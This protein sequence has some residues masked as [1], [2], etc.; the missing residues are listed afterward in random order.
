MKTEKVN[1]SL[2]PFYLEMI[3]HLKRTSRWLQRQNKA[4]NI[5]E[6]FLKKDTIAL[7][8]WRNDFL[9]KN[10]FPEWASIEIRIFQL[11]N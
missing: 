3:I 6:V 11:T 5:I 9:E 1:A 10:V 7:L 2:Q 8:S 4:S